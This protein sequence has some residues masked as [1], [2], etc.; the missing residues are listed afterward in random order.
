MSI[1][2]IDDADNTRKKEAISPRSIM[3]ES[4]VSIDESLGKFY[5]IYKIVIF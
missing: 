4:T 1:V 3:F 2:N 5:R